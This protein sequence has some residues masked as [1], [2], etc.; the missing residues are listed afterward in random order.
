MTFY[1]N[2]GANEVGPFSQQMLQNLLEK[3]IIAKGTLVKRAGSQSWTPIAEILATAFTQGPSVN[4]EASQQT[5]HPTNSVPNE[6]PKYTQEERLSAHWAEKKDRAERNISPEQRS[7]A[8]IEAPRK[9]VLADNSEST[10][11][12]NQNRVDSLKSDL[13]EMKAKVES[14]AACTENVSQKLHSKDTGAKSSF[15]QFEKVETQ[16]VEGESTAT[17]EKREADPAYNFVPKDANTGTT[18]DNEKVSPVTNFF[19]N[20]FSTSIRRGRLPYFGILVT[21]SCLMVLPR[22]L[23]EREGMLEFLPFVLAGWVLFLFV[24]ASRVR[25][26]GW[27]VSYHVAGVAIANLVYWSLPLDVEPELA[28]GIPSLLAVYGLVLLFTPGKKTQDIASDRQVASADEN[29]E[30]RAHITEKAKNDPAYKY[31]S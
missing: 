11:S 24:M 28:N 21:L 3:G 2:D 9:S 12:K 10:K 18:S 27:P 5:E 29:T 8:K 22:A 13:A 30:R 16:N 25:D 20:L 7:I 17:S 4:T 19:K 6:K 23:V 26:I 14:N 15:D 1:Y 31:I